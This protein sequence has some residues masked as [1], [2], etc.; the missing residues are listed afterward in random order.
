MLD[1]MFKGAREERFTPNCV[2]SSI[3][4]AWAARM[5]GRNA[6]IAISKIDQEKDIDHAQAE[7]EKSPGNWVPLTNDWDKEKGQICR[8]WTRHYPDKEPYRFV[9]L[10]DF[11]KE[12]LGVVNGGNGK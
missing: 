4:C 9:P 11:V 2:P 8:E 7:Y 1:W 12:Q 5:E 3:M 6:R 10:D